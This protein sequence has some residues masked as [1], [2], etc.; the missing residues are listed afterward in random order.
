MA[1]VQEEEGMAGF[2]AGE[3]TALAYRRK[4]QLGRRGGSA[5]GGTAYFSK[6]ANAHQALRQGCKRMEQA[7][8]LEGVGR[9]TIAAPQ[10]P[11]QVARGLRDSETSAMS[12]P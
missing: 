10:M 6:F 12:N 3:M 5:G 2:G 4:V 9:A 11:R 8:A 7:D 1:F